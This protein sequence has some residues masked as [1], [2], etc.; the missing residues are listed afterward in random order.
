M[1]WVVGLLAVVVVGVAGVLVWEVREVRVGA[2]G[3]QRP[4]SAPSPER[5][6]GATPSKMPGATPPTT[7]PPPPTLGPGPTRPSPGSPGAPVAAA[8]NPSSPSSAPP[9]RPLKGEVPGDAHAAEALAVKNAWTGT[10]L[11]QMNALGWLMVHGGLE[12]MAIFESL[13]SSASDS[14]VR[15]FAKNGLGVMRARFPPPSNQ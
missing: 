6:G 12:H 4:S 8:P 15:A 5:I 3:A 1:K 2:A 13:S 10:P 9:L 7:V 11:E 14:D